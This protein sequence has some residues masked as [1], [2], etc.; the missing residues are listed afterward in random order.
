MIE[1][2]E[3]AFVIDIRLRVVGVAG[4]ADAARSTQASVSCCIT[5]ADLMARGDA[6]N[7][8][9]RPLDH[10]VYE[11]VQYMVT[12]DPTFAFLSWLETRKSLGLPGLTLAEPKLAKAWTDFRRAMALPPT[13]ERSSL[14]RSGEPEIVPAG[15]RL[16][17]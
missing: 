14:E 6:P 7:P 12:D 15:K 16:A 8:R 1:I 17:S 10:V 4:I 13:L 2:N 5:C 3:A 11:Q 9:N